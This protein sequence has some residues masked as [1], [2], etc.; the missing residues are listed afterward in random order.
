MEPHGTTPGS[1]TPAE[2][3]SK[4][5]S[6]SPKDDLKSLPMPELLARLGASPDGLGQAEAQ[7]RLIQYG[8]NEIE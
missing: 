5:T 1:T 2:Q 6:T 7:K 8:P 4:E 3:G